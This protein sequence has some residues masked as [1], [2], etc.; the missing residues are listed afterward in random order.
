MVVK[1]LK[2][3]NEHLR[4]MLDFKNEHLEYKLFPARLLSQDITNVFKTLVIDRG[5]SGGF[6]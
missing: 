4:R 6:L 2:I 5:K 3:E 1:E